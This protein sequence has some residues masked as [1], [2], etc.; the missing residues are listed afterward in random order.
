MPALGVS[1]RADTP[2]DDMDDQHRLRFRVSTEEY[3]DGLMA[4]DQTTDLGRRMIRNISVLGW[5]LLAMTAGGLVWLGA[6]G[7]AGVYAAIGIS[8][9]LLARRLA[10]ALYRRGLVRTTRK[11]GVGIK[12]PWTTAI[13]DEAL[14]ADSEA[15]TT[16]IKWSQLESITEI[17]RLYLL[18]IGGEQYV[19]IP[20]TPDA[21]AAAAFISEVRERSNTPRLGTLSRSLLDVGLGERIVVSGTL[22]ASGSAPTR[23]LTAA[24]LAARGPAGGQR[25]EGVT[26]GVPGPAGGTTSTRPRSIRSRRCSWWGFRSGLTRC[27]WPGKQHRVVLVGVHKCPT[28]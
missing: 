20:K 16:T 4:I 9:V 23:R 26:D 27:G 28:G 3:I 2:G 17:D 7:L 15:A 14:M 24:F 18:G 5:I 10:R 11:H 19:M 8:S 21:E 12:G 6:P 1:A 25:A 22:P 13:T